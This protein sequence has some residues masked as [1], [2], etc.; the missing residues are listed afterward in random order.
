MY[1]Y[2]IESGYKIN[3]RTKKQKC[4]LL[5]YICIKLCCKKDML[6]LTY[7]HNVARVYSHYIL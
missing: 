3:H 7:F 5:V 4:V 6:D 2:I 1:T